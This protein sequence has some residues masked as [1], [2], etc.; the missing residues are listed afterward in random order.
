[1]NNEM[2]LMQRLA[3]SK[4]IMEKHGEIRRGDARPTTPM[5][6]NYEPVQGRYNIPEEF[7]AESKPQTKNY[8]LFLSS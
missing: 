4:Q 8:K 1:M 2:D 5:V 6:E 7:M 3:V